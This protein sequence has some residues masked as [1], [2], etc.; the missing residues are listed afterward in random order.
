MKLAD[1]EAVKAA[2]SAGGG[3]LSDKTVFVL[4]GR[5]LFVRLS[6]EWYESEEA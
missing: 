1:P 3:K 2:A 5:R 4:A 6:G